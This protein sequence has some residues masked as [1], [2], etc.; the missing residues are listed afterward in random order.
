M[1]GISYYKGMNY[2]SKSNGLSVKLY[3]TIK[4]SG[5]MVV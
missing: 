1:R 4:E 5:R 3:F 2:E